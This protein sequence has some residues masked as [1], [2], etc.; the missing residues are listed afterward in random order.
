MSGTSNTADRPGGRW[1]QSQYSKFAALRLRPAFDL[2]N[3]VDLERVETAYDLGCGAGEITRV[4]VERYPSATVVGL[5]SS[6]E[7]LAKAA[8]GGEE[9][10]SWKQADIATWEPD[11][12]AG[13]SRLSWGQ[14]GPWGRVAAVAFSRRFGNRM[15]RVRGGLW[16]R[17]A[18]L[19]YWS[20][21]GP[22]SFP[23]RLVNGFPTPAFSPAAGWTLARA[24]CSRR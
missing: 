11:R 9:R 7:M 12:P 22:W 16:M 10:P 17:G 21:P 8:G 13:S 5:D 6:P 24:R 18:G 20:F 4:L 3:Q 1:D 14:P 15:A 23:V 19:R 2:L